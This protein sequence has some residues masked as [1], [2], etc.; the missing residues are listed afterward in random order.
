MGGAHLH[1]QVVGKPER[2]GKN[3]TVKLMILLTLDLAFGDPPDHDPSIT[4][5]TGVRVFCDLAFRGLSRLVDRTNLSLFMPVNAS[6]GLIDGLGS[7]G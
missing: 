5:Q 3:L 1:D 6:E 7:R 2:H 4:C